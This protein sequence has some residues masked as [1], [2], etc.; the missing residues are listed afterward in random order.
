MFLSRKLLVTTSKLLTMNSLNTGKTV[1]VSERELSD[2]EAICYF[3][4]FVEKIK[5]IEN[6]SYLIPRT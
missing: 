4:K 6:D 1:C 3:V 5:F 2:E